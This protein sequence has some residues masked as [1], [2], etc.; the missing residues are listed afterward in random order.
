MNGLHDV[1]IEKDTHCW[2]RCGR[3]N[4]ERIRIGTD[5]SSVRIEF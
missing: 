3:E 2:D 1:L 4:G 5:S